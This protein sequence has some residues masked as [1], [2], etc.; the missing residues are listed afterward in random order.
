MA[1]RLRCDNPACRK[2]LRVSDELAGKRI[3]CPA[4][5]HVTVAAGQGI[6]SG[7]APGDSAPGGSKPAP[8]STPRPRARRSPWPWVAAGGA[9]VGAL[10]LVVGF[11]VF[12]RAASSK[13]PSRDPNVE[14]AERPQPPSPA[15]PQPE[16]NPGTIPAPSS[17]PQAEPVPQRRHETRPE[18]QP[19]PR[20]AEPE[21]EKDRPADN[22][23]SA[24]D[25]KKDLIELERVFSEPY[26]L[27]HRRVPAAS[28]K[29]ADGV[30]QRVASP[31]H[32][33]RLRQAAR[34]V[35]PLLAARDD[36]RVAFARSGLSPESQRARAVN[37]FL[38]GMIGQAAGDND[39][40]KQT[41]KE[42]ERFANQLDK[43]ATKA[44]DSIVAGMYASQAINRAD[45]GLRTVWA[46]QLLPLVR[47][48]AGPPAGG[49]P[50]IVQVAGGQAY[51]WASIRNAGGTLKNCTLQL[52]LPKSV[53]R[54]HRFH[55]FV[56]EFPAGATVFTDRLPG[57][58]VLPN[59][60]P[61]DKGCLLVAAWSDE[62]TVAE[63]EVAFVENMQPISEAYTRAVVAPD[64]VYVAPAAN[65]ER[66]LR[67]ISVIEGSPPQ[68]PQKPNPARPLPAVRQ[69][70]FPA[71]TPP[72]A[73]PE[74]KAAPAAARTP[75]Q[76][77]HLDVVAE[78]RTV[79]QGPE[80][81]GPREEVLRLTGKY[82]HVQNSVWEFT[83]TFPNPNVR[84]P[85]APNPGPAKP[86]PP[87]NRALGAPPVPKLFGGEPAHYIFTWREGAFE[88]SGNLFGPGVRFAPQ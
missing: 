76:P 27:G 52:G 6:K 80:D 35:R 72:Q 67:L 71:M 26:S 53:N 30:L 70:P 57:L 10:V 83:L 20:K 33:S 84:N 49:S 59:A 15:E 79:S 62:L 29:E 39:A 23:P 77:L 48:Q 47:Q 58:S 4:C 55:L 38:D 18:P 7:P 3:K 88:L 12:N 66:R 21:G 2:G 61:A 73:P 44:P 68:S 9:A 60:P 85:F 36:A 17:E 81:K 16:A 45:N 28:L 82:S 32:D 78:L 40:Q 37:W 50:L 75:W 64:R 25:L 87:K 8:A 42:V 65:G 34:E 54:D 86:P 56:P 74:Q 19:Q 11:V 1:I 69:S 46:K 63:R 51:V 41:E 24:G 13:T 5:G 22:G 14:V 43:E 31:G